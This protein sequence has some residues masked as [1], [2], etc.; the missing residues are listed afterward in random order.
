LAPLR[1]TGAERR[2]SPRLSALN[3]IGRASFS[4]QYKQLLPCLVKIFFSSGQDEFFSPNSNF[5]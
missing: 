4:L 3:V 1:S 2:A 5:S